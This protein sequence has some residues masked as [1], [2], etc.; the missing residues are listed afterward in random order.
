MDLKCYPL[1]CTRTKA[2]IR[3]RRHKLGKRAGKTYHYFPQERLVQRLAK[4]LK[5]QP[6]EVREQIFKER[7]YLLRDLYGETEITEA[8]V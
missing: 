2:R 6:T 8:D 3:R 7:L 1:L 5:M 4:H